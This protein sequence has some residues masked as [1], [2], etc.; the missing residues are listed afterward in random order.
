MGQQSSGPDSLVD[1]VR[2]HQCLRQRL[3]A[4]TDPL[5]ADMPFD[6]K[7]T[8]SVVQFFT[9]LCADPTPLATTAALLVF[10]LMSDIGA[11]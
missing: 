4:I 5:A 9:H 2:G 7:H 10:Q 11:G 6:R 3:A 1:D 8:R